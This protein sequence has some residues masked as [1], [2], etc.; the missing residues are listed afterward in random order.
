MKK[1]NANKLER[2]SSENIKRFDNKL[3]H[4]LLYLLFFIIISAVSFYYIYTR[5][6]EKFTFEIFKR[7]SNNYLI[8]LPILLVIY[9]VFDGLRLYYVLKSLETDIK[10]KSIFKLVFINLFVSNITPFATGGGVAQIYYLNKKGVS[11][12]NATAATTIRTVLATAFF[13]I[14]T[15]III[16]TNES[17][18]EIFSKS[19]IIFY[20]ILITLVYILFFYIAIFKVRLI[21][22]GIYIFISYLKNKNII[23][24]RKAKR[25]IKK[26]FDH[27]N[28]FRDSL[29]IFFKGDKE[30]IFKSI[31]F[32]LFFLFSQFSFSILLIRGLGYNVPLISIISIQIVII[33]FMYFAPTPGATGV[34]E[35]SY[36][37][38][39][40]KF[41][42]KSDIIPLIFTWRFFT[43]YI[44]MLIGMVLLFVILKKGMKINEKQK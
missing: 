4:Y 31:I 22:K 35:G 2:E 13:F 3:W 12:G 41:V 25:K 26:I 15:P 28:I 16:I 39:F 30:N 11:L 34:A 7:L 27:I 8:A 33:F 1:K 24:K 23:K 19:S 42:N 37:I 9:F 14:M 21:K 20:I 38:L 36:S 29:K 44:G 6:G 32:T 18:G 43:K 17:V 5:I 40:S 10:Y